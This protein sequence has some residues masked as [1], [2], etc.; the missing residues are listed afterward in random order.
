MFGMNIVNNEDMLLEELHKNVSKNVLSE[1]YKVDRILMKKK[2]PAG[3]LSLWFT[4]YSY[5]VHF[6][7][8]KG[9]QLDGIRHLN[10]FLF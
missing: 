1:L 4:V 3:S 8:N 10:F 5:I 9:Y 6:T 7:Q 2:K